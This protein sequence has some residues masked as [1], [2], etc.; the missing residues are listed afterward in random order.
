[1][2]LPENIFADN[3]SSVI[4]FQPFPDETGLPFPLNSSL[5]LKCSIVAVYLF[6]LIQ[7]TRLR[8][9]IVRYMMSAEANQGPINILIWIDQFNG[10]YLFL[11]TSGAMLCFN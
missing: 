7:G 5:E 1:M 4:S 9:V 3:F 10:V 8:A 11:T 2:A 6:I